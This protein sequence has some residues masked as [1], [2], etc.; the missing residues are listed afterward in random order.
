MTP[1]ND[2]STS[3]AN[4]ASARLGFDYLF[5]NDVTGARDHFAG[6][7]DPYHLLGLGVC[8]FLDAALGMESA[9]IAEAGRYLAQSEAGS[10]KH[11]RSPSSRPNQRFAPGLEWEVLNAEA[12]ILQGLTL[13][14]G[15]SYTGY[16]QCMYAM[17][18]AHSKFTRLYNSVF[19]TGMDGY[20][21]PSATPGASRK[22]SVVSLDAVKTAKTVTTQRSGFFSRFTASSTSLTVTATSAPAHVESAPD[23]PVEEL[24][25]S[26][27]AFGYGLFNLVFS[28]LPKR[29]QGIVGFF[30]FKHDRK[31]ALHALSVSAARNDVHAVFSSLVLMSYYSFVLLFSGYQADE[32][33]I[34]KQYQVIVDATSSRYPEGAL[35][36]LNKAKILRM[37]GDAAAALDVLQAGVKPERPGTSVQ[38]DGLLIFEMA[39]TLLGQRRYQESADAFLRIT[40]LNSWSHGTYY[41]IAAGCYISVGNYKKAQE[42][43]D[44][45]PGLIEK[46]KLNGKDIPTEVLIKKRLEFYKT[47]QKRIEG[48]VADFAR[49]IKIN[50]ADELAIFWNTH[51][52]I[53][54]DIAIQHIKAWASLTPAVTIS[55]PFIT[56]AET[57]PPQDTKKVPDLDT[58]DELAL[59]SLLMGIVHR[60][61]GA[62]VPARA[63][64]EDALAKQPEIAVSTWIGGVAMFDLA[65]LDLKEMEAQI[66]AG[67]S[68][69]HNGHTTVDAVTIVINTAPPSSASSMSGESE[70]SLDKVT[71][72]VRQAWIPVLKKAELK[73]DKAMALATNSTDLSSRLDSRITMLRDEIGTKREL[74]GIVA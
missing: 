58:P 4:L 57:S 37:S 16:V 54:Q 56:T 22:P 31:Q 65:V 36:I 19:P 55:S 33:R 38:A 47:K 70:Q 72:E 9:M 67:H 29:V 6:K 68:H 11:L 50:P 71:D 35:W 44:A 15:E 61:A 2:H 30:G 14:L 60:T 20:L 24:I 51:A 45:I 34:L 59:R 12:V 43:L 62:Y 39:W 64:L 8:V 17:N 26:G 74:L 46:R 40:E 18:N 10:K 42:L 25:I 21:T 73:L 3:V 13:A 52:R 49:V 48:K 28:L 66:A 69:G 53:N 41:F 32:Q 1:S 63:F 23:G 7:D 27:T 5:Q